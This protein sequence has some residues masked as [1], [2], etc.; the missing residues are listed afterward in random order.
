MAYLLLLV[1]L[2]A[3]AL[4]WSAV[5][6]GTVSR[7]IATGFA[8]VIFWAPISLI[9]I[10][11]A[12][13]LPGFVLLAGFAV[14]NL[15]DAAPTIL[16]LHLWGLLPAWTWFALWCCGFWTTWLCVSRLRRNSSLAEQGAAAAAPIE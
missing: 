3:A 13:G 1:L 15:F 14:L 4:I 16:Q 5:R 11:L 8:E 9:C 2:F 7:I 12:L 10:S 6:L